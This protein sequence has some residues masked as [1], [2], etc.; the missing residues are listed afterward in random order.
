MSLDL[1]APRRDEEPAVTA[2]TLLRPATDVRPVLYASP[3][4]GSYY[5]NSFLQ[6]INAPL[7]DLRRT[8]DAYVDELF[9]D[10]PAHGAAL[11]SAQYARSYVDLN[12]D[13]RE[14]DPSMFIDGPPLVSGIPGARVKAGL[15]CF[16][17]VGARGQEIYKTKIT[18]REGQ[19]RLQLVY[20][21]YH[22]ALKLEIERLQ[23]DWADIVVIDCHSMPSVQPGRA[24]LPD[25]VLGDRFGS[26]CA[27]RL[28]SL[29]EKA[30]R[31]EGLKVGRNAPYAGGYTTRK[32]GRPRRGVH[33]LQVEINR[34]LYMNE[35]TLTRLSG[36][37][38]FKSML[39]N[40]M[41]SISENSQAFA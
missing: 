37:E 21:L 38:S 12:R 30:F 25:I 34:A 32:Y 7:M 36:F 27:A 8:E 1:V 39:S 15:G 3:H 19:L 11:L 22:K 40:V 14:L 23:Q 41:T 4:S 33:V 29:V 26:S 17:R 24:S 31:Q 9:S 28:T 18:R 16:P 20:N 10:A 2:Y 5:P 6:Q 35:T 13:A